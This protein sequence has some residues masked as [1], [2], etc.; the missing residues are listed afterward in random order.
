L[1]AK[2][3]ILTLLHTKQKTLS[4]KNFFICV[5]KPRV[6]AT[7]PAKNGGYPPKSQQKLPPPAIK[8]GNAGRSNGMSQKSQQQKTVTFKLPLASENGG[9]GADDGGSSEDET[10]STVIME[11]DDLMSVQSDAASASPPP[12]HSFSPTIAIGQLYEVCLLFF[13]L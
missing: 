12:E 2:S 3:H 6:V 7:I 11:E 1:S 9:S 10:G 5:K 8:N 4:I 13:L